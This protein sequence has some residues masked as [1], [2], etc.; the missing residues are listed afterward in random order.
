MFIAGRGIDEDEDE[1]KEEELACG[2]SGGL[3]TG[4]EGGG[5]LAESDLRARL[6]RV[7]K[8]VEQYQRT[9]IAAQ[10]Y[11]E[12]QMYPEALE[13]LDSLPPE[14]QGEAVVVEMH[15]VTLMQAKRWEAALEYGMKLCELRPDSTAG[16]IQLA[17]CLHELGLTGQAKTWLMSGPAAIREEANY[18][19]NLACY[20]CV[21]GNVD[22]AR[23]LLARSIA[24][25][26]K[27]RDYAKTDPDLAVL[28][29]KEKKP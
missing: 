4:G 28:H 20:E 21:L 6:G 18:F 9:L 10:G 11:Y 27:Y 15:L 26:A 22:E 25:E 16:F 14:A 7:R 8:D 12:L 13:E 2:G 29:A 24:M 5:S 17:F 23:T 3:K 19:Y 1:E